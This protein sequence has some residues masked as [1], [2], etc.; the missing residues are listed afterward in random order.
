[1][2]DEA[3]GGVWHWYMDWKITALL[4]VIAVLIC[5]IATLVSVYVDLHSAPV[6]VETPWGATVHPVHD[7]LNPLV[8]L[9]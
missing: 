9:P 7:P 6:L 3:K 5:V 8:R 4:I 2:S 1:V